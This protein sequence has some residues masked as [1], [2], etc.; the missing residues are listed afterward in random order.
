MA[1]GGAFIKLRKGHTGAFQKLAARYGSMALPRG[2]G[3]W[4]QVAMGLRMTGSS[5]MSTWSAYESD[6]GRPCRQM[7]QDHDMMDVLTMLKRFSSLES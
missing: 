6:L 1:G 2:P 5:I 3:R 7:N 4:W